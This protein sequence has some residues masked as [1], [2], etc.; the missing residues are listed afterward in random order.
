M[1]NACDKSPLDPNH[2]V[3]LSIWHVYGAQ[4]RSPM[5]TL[6][7]RF[8]KT[9]GKECGIIISVTSVTNSTAIHDA[10]VAAAR[11]QPGSGELPDLFTCYPK[12]LVAMGSGMALDWGK[13]FTEEDLKSYVPQFI[14]ECKID[15]VLRLFPIAKSTNAL[16][17]N[18]TIFD[19]FSQ[20]TGAS[21][22]D[23]ATWEGIFRTAARYQEWSH[24]KAFFM[25][26]DWLQY[27]ML[28]TEAL[29]EPFFAG[30]AV[31]WDNP[32][33]LKVWKPLA[34]A[35]VNGQVCLT[36]GF[37]TKP[38]MMGNAI[39]GVESTASILYFKDT[40][41]LSD[42]STMPLRLLVLPEPR[43]A[44]AKR[45][46][47]QRGVGLCARPSTPEKEYASAVFCKW[48]TEAE[49]NLPFVI[50][51]GYLPVRKDSFEKLRKAEDVNFPDERYRALYAMILKIY[52][53]TD[54]FLPPSFEEY[55]AIERSFA[56]ALREV[57][58]AAKSLA[59]DTEKD[60]DNLARVTLARMEERLSAVPRQ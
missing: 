32:A 27:A 43:F 47:I 11:N 14:E 6:I 30:R 5:N 42:N 17:I 10:L 59:P 26:D 12:T 16:F 60:S 53:E 2:P 19:R 25:C 13:F 4:T 24:G 44:G 58:S 33:L 52:A 20:D 7:E 50:Q 37:A 57:L 9:V 29:G 49:N 38:M 18:R 28:N 56:A 8:N 34:E 21:Y 54:F 40:V 48:L 35:A 23:L 51:G 45:L 15:G 39:C 3:T 31:R 55:G 46:D 1:L 36:P 22:A 41:T